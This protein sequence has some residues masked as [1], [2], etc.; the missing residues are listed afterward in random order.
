VRPA[1]L[2]RTATTRF[3]CGD[4]TCEAGT[5]SCCSKDDRALCVPT[6]PAKP[7][8]RVQLLAAQIEACAQAGV[9]DVTAIDR[10]DSSSDCAAKEA[11]C[12]EF[13]FG[14]ASAQICLPIEPTQ[15]TPCDFGEVCVAGEP[16]HVGDTKCSDGFCRTRPEHLRCEQGE[17]AP[18]NVCCDEPPTC[19]PEAQCIGNARRFD[20]TGPDDCV[21]GAECWYGNQG[22]RCFN[23]SGGPMQ[24]VCRTDKDCPSEAWCKKPMRCGNSDQYFKVCT[25]E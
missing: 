2:V 1:P 16:C 20:C 5:Q 3:A 6:V 15:G 8:D 19:M 12:E 11:C 25:C 10:C 24:R 18:G 23:F 4:S 22:T 9:A 7:E 17:C 14:G 21:H 13:L